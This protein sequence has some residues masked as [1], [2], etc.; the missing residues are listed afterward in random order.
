VSDTRDPHLVEEPGAGRPSR[1][2]TV[3]RV[4][5][6]FA[7]LFGI[8]IVAKQVLAATATGSY[9]NPLWLPVIVL[10]LQHGLAAGLAAALIAV[11]IQYGNG[12]PPALM[13]EDMYGYIGRL[14]AEPIGWTCVALL[15]GYIRSRQIAQTRELEDELIER[16]EHGRAVA[17]LCTELR[18]RT[19]ILERQIA[20]NARASNI[21]VAEAVSKLHHTTFDDFADSLTRF[22]QLMTGAAEFAVYVLQEGALKVAFQPDDQHRLA[23]AA[24]VPSDDPLF[25]AIVNERRLVSAALPEDADLLGQHGVLAMPLTDHYAPERVIGMLMI[26]G[27]ALDDHPDEIERRFELTA[28]ELSRL[29]GRIKLVESWHAAASAASGELDRE[30]NGQSNKHGAAVADPAPD[31]PS[32]STKGRRRRGNRELTLQ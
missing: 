32:T 10:S 4:A 18:A 27:S 21:D 24:I 12:L 26:G 11:G 9:P 28:S 22:I 7:L 3:L 17:D 14:A 13:T 5:F 23:G 6:E 16:A 15:I 25:A 8:A 19:E 20:A 31:A 30:T 2:A 29:A 1:F